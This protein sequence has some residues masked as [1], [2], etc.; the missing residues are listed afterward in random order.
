MVSSGFGWFWPVPCF[1]NYGIQGMVPWGLSALADKTGI[2]STKPKDKICRANFC[3][4]CGVRIQI[5]KAGKFC[6]HDF[7]FP[8]FCDGAC[9]SCCGACGSSCGACTNTPL[10]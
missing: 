1:S 10:L 6:Q 8:L 2:I 5:F 9:V 7:P 4:V 3:L